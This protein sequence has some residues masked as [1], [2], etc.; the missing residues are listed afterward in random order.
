MVDSTEIL[1]INFKGNVRN[2]MSKITK[3]SE[4]LTFTLKILII[5]ALRSITKFQDDFKKK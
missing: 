1:D 2:L 4:E 5:S 3:N